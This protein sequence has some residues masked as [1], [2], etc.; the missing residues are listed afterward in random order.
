M[1]AKGLDEGD[2]KFGEIIK[3]LNW[4]EP[5]DLGDGFSTEPETFFG[6]FVSCQCMIILRFVV[7]IK[8]P[9]DLSFVHEIND[10]LPTRM[11]VFQLTD[12][13]DDIV[14][15]NIVSYGDLG[16]G[17]YRGDFFGNL[18]QMELGLCDLLFEV[19]NSIFDSR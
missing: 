14:E 2:F 3:T 10:T 1:F 7:P 19:G 5:L 11:Q 4:G 16:F 6:M 18:R 17:V 15:G 8:K 9:I 12:V 13:I